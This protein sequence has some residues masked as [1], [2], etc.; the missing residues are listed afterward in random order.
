MEGSTLYS[1][2]NAA[3]QPPLCTRLQIAIDRVCVFRHEASF[4]IPPQAE[5]PQKL[6]HQSGGS[7]ALR[8]TF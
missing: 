4:S 7:R 3:S 2:R 5:R 8:G 1:Q 6:L